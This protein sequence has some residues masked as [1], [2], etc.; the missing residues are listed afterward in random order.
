MRLSQ[1]LNSSYSLLNVFSRIW[2]SRYN[3]VNAFNELLNPRPPAMSMNVDIYLEK[4]Y[5]G[6]WKDRFVYGISEKA[7]GFI[8]RD[9]VKSPGSLY[10]GTMGSGKSIAQKGS[11]Y[12]HYA[13]N[14][15]NSLYIIFDAEKSA[16]D[17]VSLF[18]ERDGKPTIT[19]DNVITVLGSVPKFI[20]MMDLL[21]GEAVARQKAFEQTQAKDIYEYDKIMRKKNPDFKGLARIVVAFEEFWS[22]PQHKKIAFH[23]NEENID[24]P[25]GQMK[26]LMRISRSLGFSFHIATQRAISDDV[27]SAIKPGLSNMFGFRTLSHADASVAGLEGCDK[28]KQEQS[29][30]AVY[31]DGLTQF[32]FIQTEFADALVRKMKKPF[33]G[34]LLSFTVEKF[35]IACSGEGAEKLSWIKPF[36]VIT[37]NHE[38][39]DRN[40]IAKRYLEHFGFTHSPQENK[41]F[42]A[43]LIAERDGVKYAVLIP[44]ND[45]SS[46]GSRGFSRSSSTLSSAAVRQLKESMSAMGT[47]KIIAFDFEGEDSAMVDLVSEFGGVMMSADELIYA[48][49]LIDSESTLSK[50]EVAARYKTVPLHSTYSVESPTSESDDEDDEMPI[51]R[52]ST[53]MRNNKQRFNI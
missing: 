36:A 28:I 50:E 49:N 34:Q 12:T 4:V 25:A 30:R 40:E 53:S 17:Y 41:S 19:H 51:R 2:E 1:I 37:K 48:A 10:F 38:T 46:H 33:R 5:S 20:P 43:N 11:I 18:P 8:V 52:Q 21:Y 7:R 44:I 42:T 45:D 23:R 39:F 6:E 32:P 31:Q 22:V 3:P 15:E 9:P 14:N 24:T 16:T 13:T 47:T 35:R 27:P 26:A 29:G